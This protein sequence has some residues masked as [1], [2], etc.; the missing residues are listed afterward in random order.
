MNNFGN[1]SNHV[2]TPGSLAH[3]VLF[4]RISTPG[5]IRMPPIDSTV[6]DTQAVALVSA[7]IT[8]ALPQYQ[9]FA[10]WQASIAWN[11][12]DSSPGADPDNDGAANYLE[13]L[14][15]TDPLAGTNAWRITIQQT[16]TNVGITFPQI[17]NR[18]FEVQYLDQLLN[19]VPWMPLDVPGNKPF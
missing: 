10:D 2:V 9:S 11:G 15:G 1:T 3:S 12:A 13:Y 8:N 5:G 4:S 19:P 16:D 6:I 14:T 17:A 18:G 7:W